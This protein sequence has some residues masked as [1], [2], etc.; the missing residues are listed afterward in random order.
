ME[1]RQNHQL[2]NVVLI[3]SPQNLVSYQQYFVDTITGLKKLEFQLVLG[4]SGSQIL[5]ALGKS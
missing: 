2:A 5:L 3:Y 1:N 4:T